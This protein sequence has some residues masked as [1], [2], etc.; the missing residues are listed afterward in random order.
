[1]SFDPTSNATLAMLDSSP[2]ASGYWLVVADVQP[3]GTVN[4]VLRDLTTVAE[5]QWGFLKSG[6]SGYIPSARA[7]AV[8]AG[9]IGGVRVKA[10]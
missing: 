9:V 5:G 3:N 4:R 1:M 10:V 7:Y 6:C 2:A 8:V